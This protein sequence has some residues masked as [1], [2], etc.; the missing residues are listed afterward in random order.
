MKA[1]AHSVGL[2]WKKGRTWPSLSLA[3]S[4]PR[5]M[6]LM[7]GATLWEY[8]VA[9]GTNSHGF[10][11]QGTVFTNRDFPGASA[12]FGSLAVGINNRHEIVGF[13]YDTATFP[14]GFLRE[15]DHFTV[16]D[17]PFSGATATE[18]LG[19]NDRGEIVGIYRGR[20][21]RIHGFLKKGSSFT[22]L[23]VPFPGVNGTFPYGINNKGEIVGLYGDSSGG[24]G[25]SK[26]EFT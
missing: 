12:T 15:R 23:D 25:F 11:L 4:Q 2:S 16:I 26:G 10:V 21:L 7:F 17:V 22:P 20:D 3:P 13:Y 9:G 8:S 24:H 14:H 18:A 5:P 6:G 19:I 1:S